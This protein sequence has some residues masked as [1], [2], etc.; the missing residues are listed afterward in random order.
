[1]LLAQASV[2]YLNRKYDLDYEQQLA[3]LVPAPDR[4][5]LVRW[6]DFPSS[7]LDP[8]TLEDQP[9]P[10]GRFAAL[11]APLSDAKPLASMNKDFWTGLF[12]RRR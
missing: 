9:A 12:A 4:R 7:P 2:R 10:G 6:E 8:R 1:V 11:D 3:A 5:G